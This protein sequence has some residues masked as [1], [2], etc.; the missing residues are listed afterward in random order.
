MVKF[1]R[2]PGSGATWASLLFVRRAANRDVQG[3]VRVAEGGG[4]DV[5]GPEVSA[6]DE[7][8]N[9]GGV[10][11]GLS[12]NVDEGCDRVLAVGGLAQGATG[13]VGKA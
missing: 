7:A 9:L 1:G 8:R 13:G 2:E 4:E 3:G 10:V 6:G 12:S 5:S 11:T